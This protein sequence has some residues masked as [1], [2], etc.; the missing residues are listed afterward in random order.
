[1][2]DQR[3][4]L[5]THHSD[6]QVERSQYKSCQPNPSAPVFVFLNIPRSYANMLFPFKDILMNS[7][8]PNFVSF[9]LD[10]K[11]QLSTT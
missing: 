6:L 1:M 2:L 4:E 5:I 3:L 8:L 11:K 7:Q 9:S 10:N